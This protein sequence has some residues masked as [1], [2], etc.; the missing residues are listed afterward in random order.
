MPVEGR[1]GE[2][3][4]KAIAVVELPE[5]LG[6][7][8]EVVDASPA[9]AAEPRES[10]ASGSRGARESRGAAKPV[11]DRP[12][13]PVPMI[14]PPAPANPWPA[15][16]VPA[17]P[18]AVPP[19]PEPGMPPSGLPAIP[20]PPAPPVPSSFS[21]LRIS[22]ERSPSA[23]MASRSGR[24]SPPLVQAARPAEVRRRVETNLTFDRRT[25]EIPGGDCWPRNGAL[26]RR[27][28]IGRSFGLTDRRGQLDRRCRFALSK[29]HTG[30]VT[31]SKP[32]TCAGVVSNSVG[33]ASSTATQM[34]GRSQSFAGLARAHAPP[35]RLCRMRVMLCNRNGGPEV[36]EPGSGRRCRGAPPARN[37]AH[38]RKGCHRRFGRQRPHPTLSLANPSGDQSNQ[39]PRAA[40]V[41]R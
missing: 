10:R 11:I 18:P 29:A 27:W 22:S 40:I 38:G 9:G 36:L 16:P 35:C 32:C 24:S 34:S 12:P 33:P 5:P 41:A 39:P 6:R 26:R 37:G 13:A 20:E 23:R 7:E 21:A 31:V 17:V 4:T 2:V 8:R 19:T 30:P 1:V 15:N 14:G 3:R 28:V 25:E